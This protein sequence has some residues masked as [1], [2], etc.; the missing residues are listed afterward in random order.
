MSSK[1]GTPKGQNQPKL[2]K[3]QHTDSKDIENK[4]IDIDPHFLRK[5]KK[6]VFSR[7]R[8]DSDKHLPGN[9]KNQKTTLKPKSQ[10]KP[11]KS[12]SFIDRKNPNQRLNGGRINSQS[13]SYNVGRLENLRNTSQPMNYNGRVKEPSRRKEFSSMGKKV[14][15]MKNHDE[16]PI[17]GMSQDMISNYYPLSSI[18]KKRN[19]YGTPHNVE[20][21]KRFEK[22]QKKWMTPNQGSRQ[23]Q[24]CLLYTSPSPRDL[25]TSRMPSSA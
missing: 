16:K 17:Q 24:N 23:S 11:A 3:N 2:F 6:K 12:S 1:Q 21:R 22:L 5:N 19:K 9:T 7:F 13:Q 4:I 14:F 10:F 18:Q 25:S 8:G 20:S 15:E